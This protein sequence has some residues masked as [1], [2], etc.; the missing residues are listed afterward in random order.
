MYF[1]K[2]RT[3]VNI[4]TGI[5]HNDLKP[6]NIIIDPENGELTLVDLGLALVTTY[7]FCSSSKF[8]KTKN[9]IDLSDRSTKRFS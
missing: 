2:F 8:Y 4:F 5:I 1:L 6:N 3:I 7:W 9:P